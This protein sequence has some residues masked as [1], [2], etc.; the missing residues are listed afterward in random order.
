[1]LRIGVLAN[2]NQAEMIMVKEIFLF[3]QKLKRIIKIER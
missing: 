1:L 2:F 3:W